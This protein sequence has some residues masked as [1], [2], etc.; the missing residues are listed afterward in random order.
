[1]ATLERTLV[2]IIGYKQKFEK[3]DTTPVPLK[4]GGK[5]FYPKF[6]KIWSVFCSQMTFTMTYLL[7]SN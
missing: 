5:H 2:K 1:M 6:L 3:E 4:Y 7:F